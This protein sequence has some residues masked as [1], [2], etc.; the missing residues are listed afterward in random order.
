MS[1][2]PVFPAEGP[3]TISGAGKMLIV[4]SCAFLLL[5]TIFV[6]LRF[7]AR[8]VKGLSYALNDYM[9][10]VALVFAAGETVILI[11][12]STIGGVGYHILQLSYPQTIVLGKVIYT[13]SSQKNRK[14]E[15]KNLN[16]HTF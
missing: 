7:W 9:I 4:L 6:G 13:N 10:L 5:A 3:T 12:A 14:N 16:S 1:A 11:L 2:V 8:S 15:R